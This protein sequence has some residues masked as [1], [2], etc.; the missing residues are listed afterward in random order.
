MM[1]LSLKSLHLAAVLAFAGG[2]MTLAVVVSGWVRV[3]G[4]VLPHEKSIGRAILRWDRYVTVPAMFGSLG[5]GLSLAVMGGGMGQGWL[6]GKVALVVMLSGL[7]GVLRA[8]IK[9]R[10]EGYAASGS[11]W[12]R[13]SPLLITTSLTV[14]AVLVIMKPF[15]L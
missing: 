8:A 1:Y 7:H 5:L 9:A 13:A 15:D 10:T 12:Y 6:L 14:I 2:L 11:V 4:V 3:Y